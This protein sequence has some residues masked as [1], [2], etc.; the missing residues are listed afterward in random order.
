MVACFFFLSL[1]RQAIITRR[2]ATM[3]P[4]I[5]PAIELADTGASSL[6]L[7]AVGAVCVTFAGGCGVSVYHS[8]TCVSGE[9]QRLELVLATAYTQHRCS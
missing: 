2:I 1:Y 3:I 9:I 8:D 7:D 6:E 5:M 4:K